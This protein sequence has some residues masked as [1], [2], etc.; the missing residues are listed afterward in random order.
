M[1]TSQIQRE[2]TETQIGVT[3]NL[4]GQGESRVDT[5]VGFLDHMLTLMTKMGAFD[6]TLTARGDLK[7][8][9]HHTIED[10]GIALGKAVNRA[11]GERV[12]IKRYGSA[13]VPMDEALV[14]VVLDLSN[15][16]YLVWDVPLPYGQV[17][18]FPL[19]MAEEFMRAFAFNAG[20]TLHVRM[21]SGKNAHHILEAVFKALGF[22]LG[23]GLSDNPR[24]KGVLSTKGVL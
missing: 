20:I 21:L 6:L 18:E 16:P 3:I 9:P 7:V 12:G 4:D 8:D 10:V 1:R 17:G 19:E 2:T 14:Q 13:F 24:I 22:A 11:A 5:G 23:E 15:R